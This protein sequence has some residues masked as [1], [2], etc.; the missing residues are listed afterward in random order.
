MGTPLPGLVHVVDDDAAFRTAMERRLKTA[1]FEVA[2]YASAQ[3]LLDRLPS[4]SVL[5]CILLD[6][7]IPGL[8]GPE[9][10][11]R[12]SELGST[13]PIIFLTGYPD[14]PTTVRGIKAGAEDFL[15]KPVSSD[16]LLQAVERA[17][18][19]HDA[20]YRQKS[21]LD[22]GSR[23]CRDIDTARAGSLRSHRSRPDQQACRQSVGMHGAHHQGPP[24]TGDGE[25]A[26]PIPCGAG[27]SGRAGRRLGQRTRQ[28]N[29]VDRLS[30]VFE[31]LIVL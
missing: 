15:T 2:T 14:I 25:N 19:R 6:V 16:R 11:D 31:L 22:V 18:A 24:P 27:V 13:L 29:R 1:G 30:T 7:R 4:D 5:G 3:H 9:L 26:S 12:L 8:S 17:I 28:P 10:Q 21:T 20:T 23:S